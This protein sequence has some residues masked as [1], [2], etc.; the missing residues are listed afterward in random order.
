MYRVILLGASFDTGNK[1]VSALA[2][3]LIEIISRIRPDA[4]FS[5]FIGNRSA[6]IREISI[7]GKKIEVSIINYRLSPKAQLKQH[8]F[9]LFFMS[10]LHRVIPLSF[11]KSIIIKSNSTL[12]ALAEADFIGDIH[13]GDSFSDIY[14]MR[15]IIFGSIP[16]FI[17][18]LLGKKLILLP[19]TYG[20]FDSKISKIISRSILKRAEYVLSRDKEGVKIAREIVGEKDVGRILFCPDVAFTMYSVVPESPAIEPPL[21][22]RSSEDA[23]IGLN[24]NGLL[25]NG[26][27][28]R[29]NM[30]GL[31]FD[32]GAFVHSLSERILKETR[33]H[34]LLVPHTFAPDGHVE[35]DPEACRQVFDAFKS[36]YSG[37]IHRVER[38]YDQFEIKG[39]IG[40]CDFF[41]GSRMHACIAALSQG[42][43]AIGVA[44]SQKFKGVFDSIGL[45]DM[46]VDA[47]SMDMESTI[48][49]ILEMFR[50]RQSNCAMV[51]NQVEMAKN[52][53]DETF[54]HLLVE[55][56]TLSQ[57]YGPR[58]L[59]E[60]SA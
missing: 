52:R 12:K 27:Y 30:F 53:L 5:F 1:G 31:K 16:D 4:R 7:Q 36:R 18:L 6:G 39:I 49:R 48:R 60:P 29:K 13:G 42:I 40:L 9:Y 54:F 33:A 11:I 15:R 34:L 51:R 17:V 46:V 23:L 28:T 44:Y 25:F 10:F 57:E 55:K 19:Q 58:S 37:R 47:R 43:P 50:N 41:V 14:G 38:E 8:L 21:F 2:A 35:S 20:P 26:G 24:I 3:S 56:D 22:R 45:G 32:Y 59:G